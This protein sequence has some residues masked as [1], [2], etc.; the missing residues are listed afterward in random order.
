MTFSEFFNKYDIKF[1][2]DSEKQPGRATY[3]RVLDN[4]YL[5]MTKEQALQMVAEYYDHADEIFNSI[6]NYL[7]EQ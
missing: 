1:H 2:M 3:S 7:D 4:M 6:P 5:R